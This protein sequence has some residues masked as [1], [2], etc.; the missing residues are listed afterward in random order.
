MTHALRVGSVAD[1][2]P[3]MSRPSARKRAGPLTA[4]TPFYGPEGWL[5]ASGRTEAST[6]GVEAI[7]DRRNT[8]HPTIAAVTKP[9]GQ[10]ISRSQSYLIPRWGIGAR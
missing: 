2:I 10:A 6:L 5:P 1:F 4:V 3:D 8:S 7:F 9:S